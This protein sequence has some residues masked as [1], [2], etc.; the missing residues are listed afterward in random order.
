MLHR[1]SADQAPIAALHYNCRRSWTTIGSEARPIG[2]RPRRIGIAALARRFAWMLDVD[3]QAA[4]VGRHGR[5]GDF[6]ARGSGEKASDLAGRDVGGEHLVV[7]DLR[8]RPSVERA[9]GDVRLNPQNAV[10]I[11]PQAVGTS[12]DFDFAGQFD[13]VPVCTLFARGFARSGLG[14]PLLPRR[15]L[16]VSAT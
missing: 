5:A 11:E 10:R 7:A 1:S 8:V 6:T 9:R 15:L 16:F 2:D 12:L 14:W 3:E 13:D 4:A